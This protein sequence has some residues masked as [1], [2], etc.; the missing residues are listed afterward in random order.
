M[1]LIGAHQIKPG[2]DGQVL[3]MVGGVPTWTDGATVDIGDTKASYAQTPPSKWLECDNRVVAQATYPD[4]YAAIGD[5][6]WA[7]KYPYA[8]G[9]NTVLTNISNT[10]SGMWVKYVGSLWFAAMYGETQEYYTSSDGVAWTSRSMP[11]ASYLHDIAYGAGVYVAV[12]YA[13]SGNCYTSSSGTGS[14]TPQTLPQ[15]NYSYCVT[16]ANSIF[17]IGGSNNSVVAAVWTSSDGTTWT[18][19]TN[20]LAGPGVVAIHYSP[21]HDVWLASTSSGNGIYTCSNNTATGT[22]TQR[23]S[24]YGP[25]SQSYGGGK[26]VENSSGTII[27]WDASQG[28][29]VISSAPASSAWT[30]Y[31]S[32]Q[33]ATLS[34]ATGFTG[35]GTFYNP[36]YDAICISGYYSSFYVMAIASIDNGTSWFPIVSDTNTVAYAG[37]TGGNTIEPG[38]NGSQVIFPNFVSGTMNVFPLVP[39]WDYSTHFPLPANTADVASGEKTYIYAG[40]DAV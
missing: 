26:F 12:T 19:N 5:A 4:L 33:L 22:W 23:M 21:T 17:V 10:Q 16:F 20:A 32:A 13:N 11:A 34:G 40:Q 9:S 29:V 1:P 14:W 24:S 18:R 39:E 7:L 31:T 25:G 6:A 36:A 3:M 15:H 8:P 38:H 2:T 37:S 30:S 27:G 28:R 35:K